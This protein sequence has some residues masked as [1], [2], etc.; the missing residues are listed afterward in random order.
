MSSLL[1]LGGIVASVAAVVWHEHSNRRYARNLLAARQALDL[2]TFGR[3]YFGES[4]ERLRLASRV[5]EVLARHLPFSLEGLRPEDAFNDDLR[6]DQLDSMSN[7][8]F[9]IDLENTLAVRIP[10][11]DMRGIRTFRQ[12]VD[13]LESRVARNNNRAG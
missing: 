13:Y 3:R 12:L 2:E 1:F 11:P 10:D 8:E 4:E 5:R 6:M 9:V 7:A